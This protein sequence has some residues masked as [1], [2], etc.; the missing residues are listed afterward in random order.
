MSMLCSNR[1][2]G[3]YPRL[4]SKDLGNKWKRFTDERWDNLKINKANNFPAIIAEAHE[5]MFKSFST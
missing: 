4:L 2:Q 1:W 3:S 5:L